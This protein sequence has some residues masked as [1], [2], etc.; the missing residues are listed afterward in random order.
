MQLYS[1]HSGSLCSCCWIHSPPQL[2]S[3]APQSSAH[4]RTLPW[5]RRWALFCLRA[6]W[7]SEQCTHSFA[8]EAK[9]ATPHV[10]PFFRLPFLGKSLLGHHCVCSLQCRQCAAS[11]L[12]LRRRMRAPQSQRTQHRT[13]CARH[14]G[15]KEHKRLFQCTKHPGAKERKLLF[16]PLRKVT[17][18]VF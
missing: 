4:W 7:M 11:W 15:A 3:N 9:L 13:K 14:P 8:W 16:P 10:P 18:P 1:L 17:T 5:G 6:F 12:C 2:L